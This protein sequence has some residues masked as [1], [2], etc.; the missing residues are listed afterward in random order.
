MPLPSVIFPEDEE[1][2]HS[3][4][5]S[6]VLSYRSILEMFMLKKRNVECPVGEV[7]VFAT[8]DVINQQ[9]C[10]YRFLQSS[11]HG[12]NMSLVY[13]L[14]HYTIFSAF[15]WGLSNWCIQ[16]WSN[17]GVI[18]CSDFP[19]EVSGRNAVE[20]VSPLLWKTRTKRRRAS[21]S[22]EIYSE[23]GAT[24]ADIDSDSGYCSPK[25]NQASGATQRT[26]N[27]T[28]ST[29]GFNSRPNWWWLQRY[30][31]LVFLPWCRQDDDKVK[32]EMW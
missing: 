6:K 5:K 18:F 24:E 25:H 15:S 21:N 17:S 20:R 19:G 9:M 14:I 29:V 32:I 22:G 28:A 16:F 10:Y 2:G 30:V 8:F 12:P 7:Y 27:T 3:N 31:V 1:A 26:E 4:G 23:Q 11:Q 13:P